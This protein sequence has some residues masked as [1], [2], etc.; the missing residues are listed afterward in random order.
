MKPGVTFQSYPLLPGKTQDRIVKEEVTGGRLRS[1]RNELL[2]SQY[3]QFLQGF[4]LSDG[5]NYGEADS[6]SDYQ[7]P[8]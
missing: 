6:G 2:I 5:A 7:L 4:V 8:G 3:E 1:I